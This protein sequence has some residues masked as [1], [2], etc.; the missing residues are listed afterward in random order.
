M[1][2]RHALVALAAVLALASA[3]AVAQDAPKPPV[4]PAPAPADAAAR[5][6]AKVRRLL[7]L[8]RFKDFFFAGFD[9]TIE[10]QV[11]AGM[12]PPEFPEKFKEIADLEGLEKIAVDAWSEVID[13]PTLDASLAFFETEAG[14]KFVDA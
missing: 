10:Q 8:Q 4:A 12:L 7:E 5:K 1:S 14:R 11:A 9:A 3:P 2:R 13:E 6:E